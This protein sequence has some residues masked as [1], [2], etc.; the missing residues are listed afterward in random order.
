M[1]I[2]QTVTGRI[3]EAGLKIEEVAKR[4]GIRRQTFHSHLNKASINEEFWSQLI[5]KV[6]EI[7]LSDIIITSNTNLIKEPNVSYVNKKE[8]IPYF[9]LDITAG[10]IPVYLDR[11]HVEPEHHINIFGFN[12]C[13]HAFPVYGHSMHPVI[14]NGDVGLFK[15]IRDK[16]IIMWGSIYL[17]ITKDYRTIKFLRKSH[18]AENVILRS[19]S[20]NHDDIEIPRDDILELF[21]YKGKI[22]RTQM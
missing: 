10:E 16:S 3:K 4:L 6:P 14:C 20:A 12:D 19:H 2:Y 1:S 11:P 5:E 13:T 21:L 17:V 7:D 9:D 22:E 18:N 15:Y 8:G